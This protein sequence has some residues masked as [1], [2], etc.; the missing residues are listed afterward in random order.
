MSAAP[1]TALVIVSHSA[2]LAEGVV[3]VAAQMAPDVALRAAGGT[4]E[5]GIGTS[6]DAV[7]SAVAELL[8]SDGVAGVT[9]LTDLGSATMTAEAVLESLEDDDAARVTLA[10]GPLVEGAVAGA[11]AAQGGADHAAV[12]RV[13][14][15]AAGSFGGAAEVAAPVEGVVAAAGA[16]AEGD[17]GEA[18]GDGAGALSRTLTLTNEVGLHARPAALLARLVAGYDATVAV[19]GVDGASVLALMGLGL[20]KGDEMLVTA[21]G[22]QAAEALDGVTAAVAEGFGEGPGAR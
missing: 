19:N 11:V 6:F 16:A 2:R 10:D 13:V 22:P 15:E 5:G 8:G 14:A 7:S 4:D 9:V 20:E 21:S 18:G 3:E 12:A 1:A 17:G